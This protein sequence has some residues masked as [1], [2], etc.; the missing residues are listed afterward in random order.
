MVD[1]QVT[2]GFNTKTVI[3]DLDAQCHIQRLRFLFRHQQGLLPLGTSAQRR[4]HRGGHSVQHH[5]QTLE[6]LQQGQGVSPGAATWGSHSISQR[7]KQDWN[8]C[9]YI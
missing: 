7:L 8:I 6:L 5:A 2:M 1:P 3:H 9:I 4:H